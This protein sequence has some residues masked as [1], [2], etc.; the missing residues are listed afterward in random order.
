MLTFHFSRRSVLLFTSYNPH[1]RQQAEEFSNRNSSHATT[2][3]NLGRNSNNITQATRVL[4]VERPHAPHQKTRN[5]T[6]DCCHRKKNIAPGAA[7]VLLCRSRFCGD[8]IFTVPIFTLQ[9]NGM[10]KTAS[11][12][13]HWQIDRP[14]LDARIVVLLVSCMCFCLIVVAVILV[15]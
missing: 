8:S 15:K 11:A 1:R 2:I 9:P 13:R 6:L 3:T 14:Y 12:N 7:A 10:G 5:R 4:K